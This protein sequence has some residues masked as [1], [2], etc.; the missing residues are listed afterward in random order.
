MFQIFV[1][2]DDILLH[3]NAVVG[4]L[5]FWCVIRHVSDNQFLQQLPHTLFQCI[6]CH[7]IKFPHYYC[8]FC[9]TNYSIFLD[10]SIL[11]SMEL[12]VSYLKYDLN[13]YLGCMAC[14]IYLSGV[15]SWITQELVG[16]RWR[17]MKRSLKNLKTIPSWERMY[18]SW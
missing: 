12:L 4:S 8:H 3:A 15:M 18:L 1:A 9:Q 7:F 14:I 17:K 6:T 5:L 10:R 13:L 11:F 16:E 2:F